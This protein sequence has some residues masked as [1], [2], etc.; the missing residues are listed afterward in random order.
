MA[1]DYRDGDFS[2]PAVKGVMEDLQ[3]LGMIKKVT[4]G[5]GKCFQD[6]K[7]VGTKKAKFYLDYLCDVPFP[8]ETFVIPKRAH[9]DKKGIDGDKPLSDFDELNEGKIGNYTE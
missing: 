7:Y 5:D 1:V 9:L 3:Q 4:K 8:V 6:M 2:A